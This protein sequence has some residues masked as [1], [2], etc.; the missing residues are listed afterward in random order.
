M[1]DCAAK[2]VAALF[3]IRAHFAIVVDLAVEDDGD[4]LV[5]VEDGCSPVTR[6]M[7][8][9]RRIP[10]ATPVVTS[11][12]S[13]SGPRCTMRSHIACSSSF[14]PSGGGVRGSRLAQPVIPHIGNGER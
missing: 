12:P 5:F 9:R 14:A 2:R 4:A 8:A 11:K 10:S 3:Q 13:E 6:S 7:I 1:S